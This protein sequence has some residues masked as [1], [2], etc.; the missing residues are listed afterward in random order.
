MTTFRPLPHT[1]DDDDFSPGIAGVDLD[2]AVHVDEAHVN[3][4]FW[5]LRLDEP[6]EHGCDGEITPA[7]LRA[8]IAPITALGR[9]A[10]ARQRRLEPL[11]C[12]LRGGLLRVDAIAHRC[13]H[14]ALVAVQRRGP[15]PAAR[16]SHAGAAHLAGVLCE[17]ELLAGYCA[18]RRC[19]IE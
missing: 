14:R 12:V 17:L 16:T 5:M 2:R 10:L 13:A 4:L 18:A 1:I 19:S 7:A 3:A 15:C 9:R 6:S 11:P 8:R